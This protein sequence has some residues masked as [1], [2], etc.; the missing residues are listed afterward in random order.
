MPAQIVTIED[1]QE[2]KIALTEIKNQLKTLKGESTKKWLKTPE[3]RNL[4]GLSIGTLQHLRVNGT[5]PYTKIGGVLYYDQDDIFKVMLD[6]R[7][8]NRK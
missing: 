1:L 7:K 6:N 2:L 3:V 4:L 8:H 5:L